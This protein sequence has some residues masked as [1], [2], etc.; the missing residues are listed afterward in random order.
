MKPL[1]D[2]ET[3]EKTASDRGISLEKVLVPKVLFRLVCKCT[4]VTDALKGYMRIAAGSVMP[5]LDMINE[6]LTANKLPIIEVVDVNK[7]LES[8]GVVSTYTPWDQANITFIP[9]GKLGVIHN[10]IALEQIKPVTGVNYANFNGV[11]LSKWQQHSPFAEYTQGEL[12]AFPGVEAIDS[13]F[14]METDA[15][16]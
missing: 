10:A 5:T 15:T 12:S 7:S 4:E 11:L 9:T 6:Y 14:I 8:D 13:I 2:F 16:S 3:A 1:T